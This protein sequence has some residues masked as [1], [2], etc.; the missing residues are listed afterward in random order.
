VKLKQYIKEIINQGDDSGNGMTVRFGLPSGLE[1]IGLPTKNFYGGHWD[2][3]PTWN[4]AVLADKPFLVDS[5]RFGQGK[6][7]VDMMISTLS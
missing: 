3:G 2:L 6:N 7:L 5:G 4:Y 1:I